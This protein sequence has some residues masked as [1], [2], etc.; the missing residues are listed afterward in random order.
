MQ[1]FGATGK[2]SLTPNFLAIPLLYYLF[3]LPYDKGFW[4]QPYIILYQADP[5][6]AICFSAKVFHV[7]YCSLPLAAMFWSYTSQDHLKVK[8]C[9]LSKRK[10]IYIMEQKVIITKNIEDHRMC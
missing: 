5:A 8:F 10:N 6:N 7:F 1:F 2:L 9:F 4:L 3:N